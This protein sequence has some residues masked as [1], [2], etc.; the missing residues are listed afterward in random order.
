MTDA[1]VT[2]DR[3]MVSGAELYWSNR[4]ARCILEY[5]LDTWP[6]PR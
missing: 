1:S 3:F 6:K 5:L 2:V 4:G